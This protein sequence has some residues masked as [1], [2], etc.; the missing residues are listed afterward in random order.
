MSISAAVTHLEW[1]GRTINLI[2][3][4][5]EPS[6]QADVLSALR[7]VE[8]AIVTVSGVMGVEVG[9]DRLWK[10]CDELGLSRLVLVNLLDRERAD[11][12]TALGGAAQPALRP[13][14]RGRDPD[15]R[16]A[17]VPRRGRPR[18]HGRLPARRDGAGARRGD[19]DIPD[20][21]K[22]AGRRVPRQADGRG[23]R[24]VGRADGALP[25]G[26]R[27]QPRGDGRGAQEAGHR[28]RAVPGRLRRRHPQHRLARPARPDRRGA[29]VAGPG[30]QRARGGRRRRR[31]A[32]VF[33][34]IADPFSGKINLLRVFA[35][36]LTQRLDA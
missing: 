15:R 5:G 29:A 34:T 33:K 11:F 19:A 4:P 9:T 6:F 32:Y 28:R 27:D 3:T 24:D 23:R 8:G 26:R 25:G 17:R 20:D 12:F 2:D 1:E 14:R 13:L 7:V 31:V 10:R 21:M 35:G 30:A 16:R 36:T 22:R 18:A